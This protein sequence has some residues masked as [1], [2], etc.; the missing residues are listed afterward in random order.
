MVFTDG[1]LLIV[2]NDNKKQNHNSINSV[3]DRNILIWKKSVTVGITQTRII[4]N[5]Y[6]T[7]YNTVLQGLSRT[8]KG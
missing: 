7:M 3:N 1:D 2:P 6:G 5:Y 8:H 4:T